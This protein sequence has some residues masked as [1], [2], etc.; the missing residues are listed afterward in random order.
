MGLAVLWLFVRDAELALAPLFGQ[1]LGGLAVGLPIAFLFRRFYD[2]R[3]DLRRLLHAV[4]YAL[5]YLLTF[6][7]EVIVANVDVAYRVLAPGSTIEPE[8]ILIPLRVES[9]FGVTTIANSITITPGTITQD[10]DA[11]RNALYVHVID[12]RDPEAVVA[13]IRTWEDYALLIFDEE[14]EP[15]S[16]A[17][18]IVVDGGETDGR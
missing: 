1:F 14:L 4:P 11:E 12:G 8:V 2:D 7:R 18:E 10:Y 17:P 3:I 15:G 9:D 6:S 16:P 13:P 5:L